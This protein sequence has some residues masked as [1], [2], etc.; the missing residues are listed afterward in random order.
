VAAAAIADQA[1]KIIAV[2]NR[3]WPGCRDVPIIFLPAKRVAYSGRR[4]LC[5][6][7]EVKPAG[8]AGCALQDVKRVRSIGDLAWAGA[9]VCCAERAGD[10][11]TG[12][13]S[14]AARE[15]HGWPI[16]A[17]AAFASELAGE[18]YG[19]EVAGPPWLGGFVATITTRF[20][21]HGARAG[22]PAAV[23]RMGDHSSSFSE[24]TCPAAAVQAKWAVANA[25]A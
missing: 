4:R 23:A 11:E 16:S 20:L 18:I 6:T 8:S 19:R 3:Q 7:C 10:A 22:C 12:P 17:E 21:D 1:K 2:E 13:T 24:Q 9:R 25:T 5:G 15:L 14:A